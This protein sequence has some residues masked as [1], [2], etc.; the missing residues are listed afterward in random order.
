MASDP[1]VAKCPVACAA[2]PARRATARIRWFSSAT[3]TGEEAEL[4]SC[5]LKAPDDSIRALRGK[6]RAGI[7]EAEV[8]RIR[9]LHDAV[10]HPL[11]APAQ[12]LLERPRMVEI[13]RL[14]LLSK[15][16]HVDGGRDGAGLN[17]R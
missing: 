7:E 15:A 12:H 8:A 10:L 6:I 4:A 16:R 1:P 14:E 11:D 3:G 9:H 13:H 5:G 17:A 2:M